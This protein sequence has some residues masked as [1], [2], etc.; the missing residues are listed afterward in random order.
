MIPEYGGNLF[1]VHNF[2]SK[3]NIKII[4]V[5][6]IKKLEKIFKKSQYILIWLDK[7]VI[8]ILCQI[9]ILILKLIP[10]QLS[11]LESI[12]LHNPKVEIVF[13]STRQIYGK[14]DFLPVNEIIIR[15][16][17]VNGINK[18]AGEQ[19]HLLYHQVYELHAVLR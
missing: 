5:R 1:N 16:V 9:H 18:N 2:E 15:P 10:W 4:D 13:A 17:D 3:L 11:I 8:W 12:R 14:P 6:E 7:L 19:Y